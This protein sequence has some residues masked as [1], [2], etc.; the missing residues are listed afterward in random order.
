[1]AADA[2]L[3]SSPG[4]VAAWEASG[5]SPPGLRVLDVMEAST[6]LRPMRQPEAAT[7]SGMAGDPAVLWVGR[8]T[9]NKDPLT[10]L[11]GFSRFIE[12]H[13]HA[14]LSMVFN[15]GTLVEAVRARIEH[16]SRLKS[17]VRVVGAVAADD[18][19]A[20]F[21]AADI[22]V[23]AS[24]REGSG[25]AAIEAMACGAAPVLTDIPSFAALTNGGKV[26][27]LWQPGQAQELCAALSRTAAAPRASLRASVRERFT[28]AL[29]WDVLGRR[30]VEIY[31]E[32]R[33]R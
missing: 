3:V 31:R 6:A 13:P 7:R 10:M 22:F 11:E 30:A 19:A 25:Y 17:R 9:P 8:L 26:G 2:L 15:G 1:M 12:R 16:D 5:A 32:V 20:Y 33:A 24:H 18:M 28:S 27:A 21:S 23:S 4:H 29:S 14:A